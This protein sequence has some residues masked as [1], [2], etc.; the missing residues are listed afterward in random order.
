M[1][2]AM[3]R[4]TGGARAARSLLQ[5]FP[6]TVFLAIAFRQGVPQNED[7]LLAFMAGGVAALVQLALVRVLFRHAPMSRMI[8]GVN[9]YLMLGGVATI[10]NHVPTLNLLNSLRESG[11]FLCLLGVGVIT[12][13]MSPYGFVGAA[14]SA[15]PSRVRGHSMALLGLAILATAASF[16]F[17]GR[18]MLS[19]VIPL[20]VLALASRF[21]KRRLERSGT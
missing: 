6:L 4:L 14:G 12:T 15:N 9:V 3:T 11:L 1:V 8:I 2:Q 20:V 7:W 17:R 19:A 21:A 16:H 13:L 5:F 18:M 10:I